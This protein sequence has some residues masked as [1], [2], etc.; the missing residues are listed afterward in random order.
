MHRLTSD[1]GDLHIHGKIR[2]YPFQWHWSNGQLKLE[3][4]KIVETRKISRTFLVMC[5]LFLAE[6][7]CIE[8]EYARDAS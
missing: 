4:A 8:L 5:H 7:L 1:L 3:S 6:D 2:K